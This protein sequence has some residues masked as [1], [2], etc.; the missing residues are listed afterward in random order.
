M[1]YALK[2][3]RI[4]KNNLLDCCEVFVR[5][6][7]IDW[8]KLAKQKEKGFG[9]PDDGALQISGDDNLDRFSWYPRKKIDIVEKKLNGYKCTELLVE[10]LQDTKHGRADYVGVLHDTVR[11]G[12]GD[13]RFGVEGRILPIG[14]QVD[15][16]LDL[17]Q[18][19]NVLGRVWSFWSPYA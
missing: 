11:G 16:L 2:P 1:I 15:C 10:E 19:P 17:A 4:S 18:D 6:P 7:L 14:E 12:E 13:F 3:L 8:M 9:K 5:D